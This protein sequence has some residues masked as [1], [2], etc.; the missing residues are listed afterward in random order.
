MLNACSDW[1][2]TTSPVQNTVWAWSSSNNSWSKSTLGGLDFDYA[3]MNAIPVQVPEQSLVFYL[4]GIL[5]NGSNES[6]FPSMIIF[7]TSTRDVRIVSTAAI[8]RSASRVGAVLQ[9]LPLLGAKGALVLLGG[10]TTHNDNLTRDAWGTMVLLPL[11]TKISM[12]TFANL[13]FAGHYPHLR[14]RLS[15][16]HSKWNLVP[17]K[18]PRPKSTA[19]N[20]YLRRQHS[21]PRQH[22]LP[23]VSSANI[24]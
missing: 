12:L 9:Y 10:A 6:V 8:S 13:G 11:A 1:P 22:K 18:H 2:M 23:H 15:G 3:L 4:N 19:Q 17:S 24:V 5:S 7:N 20:D 21:I 16:Q 14:H